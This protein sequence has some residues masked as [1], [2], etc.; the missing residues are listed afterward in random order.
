MQDRLWG[1]SRW[2]YAT[3]SGTDLTTNSFYGSLCSVLVVAGQ[4]AD[5]PTCQLVSLPKVKSFRRRVEPHSCCPICWWLPATTFQVRQ[6][7]IF[8]THD[9][10]THKNLRLSSGVQL[11]PSVSWLCIGELVYLDMTL[12]QTLLYK[13]HLTKTATKLKSGNCR[14]AKLAGATWGASASTLRTSTLA[15]CY[16][17]AEYCAPIWA[18]SSYT[19]LV[20]G[21]LNNSM[22]LISDTLQPTQLHWLPLLANITPS[23]LCWKAACDA[24]YRAMLCYHGI[25]LLS[26][27]VCPYIRHELVL[28]QNG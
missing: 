22:Q 20:D 12:D 2:R 26:S 5:M 21:Q 25:C 14:L 8:D 7:H 17:V 24:F 16:S 13:E 27:C 9:V 4:L 15:L 18:R 1:Q 19:K 3:A 10:E 28:C 6:Q 23:E 11:Y